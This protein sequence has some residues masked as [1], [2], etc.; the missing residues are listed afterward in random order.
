M[1]AFGALAISFLVGCHSG[2]DPMLRGDR[3]WAD[4]N[5][6]AALG[7]YRLAARQQG[8]AAAEMRTAHAYIVTGQLDRAR[9]EYDAILQLDPASADQAIF[10]YV[11]LAQTSLDRGDHYGAARAAEAALAMRPGLA[12]PRMSVT[13]ARY[14]ATIGDLTRALQFYHRAL[15]S[16]DGQARPG[17]LY[18]VAALTERSGSCVDGLPYY[19]AFSEHSGNQDSVTEARWRMGT[20]GLEQGQQARVAGQMER[21]L[22]MVQVTLDLGA[23]QHL[24]DQAWFERAEALDALGRSD[25]AAAAF[26]R[27]LDLSSAGRTQLAARAERRLAEIRSRSVP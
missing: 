16:A 18:E 14:Y 5:Y 26:Q 21:A 8:N 6:V 15:S 3:Y 9:K 1:K 25:D 7:E 4:S 17:L 24:L 22:E 23:P 10:D 11:S 13:L 12:L 27:V 20:C 2:A 19:Q